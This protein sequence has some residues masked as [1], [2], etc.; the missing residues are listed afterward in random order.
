MRLISL[1]DPAMRS[2]RNKI[3]NG[4]F[5]IDQ[6]SLTSVVSN[7][8]PGGYICDRW[9]A[10]PLGCKSEIIRSPRADTAIVIFD[11]TILQV[12]EGRLYLQERSVYTLSWNGTAKARVHTG[13][14]FSKYLTSPIKIVDT[15]AYENLKV[16]FGPGSVSL[17]QLEPGRRSTPFERRDD[18][19]RRCQRYYQRGE[20]FMPATANQYLGGQYTLPV[21]MR[22]DPILIWS[23]GAGNFNRISTANHGSGVELI[24]GGP[25]A[26]ATQIRMDAVSIANPGFWAYFSF[27]L[28]SEI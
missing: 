26:T 6:R 15:D 12:I 9:R 13:E 8:S 16:E 28:L 7:Q 2:F 1:G 21:T 14:K 25:C 10:G 19:L 18:E 27:E 24:A 22:D 4:D 23:D 20:M 3:I 11:G 5:S 17:V